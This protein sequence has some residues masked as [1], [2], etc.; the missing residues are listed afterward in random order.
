MSAE[1]HYVRRKDI[2]GA[3]IDLADL[4]TKLANEA[5]VQS[6]IHLT[7]ELGRDVFALKSL[8]FSTTPDGG[9]LTHLTATALVQHFASRSGRRR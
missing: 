4:R 7:A 8:D 5:E 9:A 2:Y 1:V 3:T 6:K